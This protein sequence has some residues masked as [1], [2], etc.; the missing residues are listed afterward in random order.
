MDSGR[1]ILMG[2]VMPFGGLQISKL[3]RLMFFSMATKNVVQTCNDT[4]SKQAD[5]KS[6][7]QTNELKNRQMD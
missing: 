4:D 5:R 7:R 2:R 1:K 3:E 6:D